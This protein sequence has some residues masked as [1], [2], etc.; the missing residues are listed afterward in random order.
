MN[1]KQVHDFEVTYLGHSKKAIRVQYEDTEY[2]L[3]FSEIEMQNDP[4]KLRRGDKFEV[5]VPDWLVIEKGM[6]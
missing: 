4:E 3:P 1:K 6:A 5:S 2:W